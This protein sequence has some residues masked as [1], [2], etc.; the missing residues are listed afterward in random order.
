[1]AKE[2][3][4]KAAA[5]DIKGKQYVLV[6]DRVVYFNEAYPNG[7]IQTEKLQSDVD[8]QVIVKATV[9]PDIDKPTRYFTGYS[10]TI[11]GQGMV[12]STAALENA[13]TSA[14]GRALAFMGIGV[15]ESIASADEMNKAGAGAKRNPDTFKASPPAQNDPPATPQQRLSLADKMVQA[16]RQRPTD[17]WLAKLTHKQANS[18]LGKLLD[19]IA[20]KKTTAPVESDTLPTEE[21]SADP[22]DDVL[23]GRAD[24][25]VTLDEIN[26]IMNGEEAQ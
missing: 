1:M 13:E 16:G 6:A 26:D 24:E 8:K 9:Y 17:E 19:E 5:V 20:A 23:A 18:I 15:I 2:R 21:P 11:M 7:A 12:N 25:P 3:S 4:L 22:V 10:Q 14:V